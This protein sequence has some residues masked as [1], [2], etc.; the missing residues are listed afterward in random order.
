M[1]ALLIVDI[2]DHVISHRCLMRGAGH[3]GADHMEIRKVVLLGC[4]AFGNSKEVIIET[5]LFL[6]H[7][8]NSAKRVIS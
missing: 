3:M 2:I 1:G 7:E 6:L 4:L 5:T 8:Y